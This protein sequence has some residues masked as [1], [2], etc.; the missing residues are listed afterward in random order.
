MV[1]PCDT[2]QL[3]NKLRFFQHMLRVFGLDIIEDEMFTQLEKY[4]QLYQENKDR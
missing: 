2:E 4:S 3:L 1:Y